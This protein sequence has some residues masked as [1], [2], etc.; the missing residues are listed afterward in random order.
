MLSYNDF[1]TFLNGKLID[2]EDPA[3]LDQ[4]FDLVIAWVDAIG[5]PRSTI[6]H[7]YAYQIFTEPTATTSQYFDIIPNTPSGVPLQGDIVVWS[8][9]YNGTAGHTGVAT[10]NGNTNTFDCF[11]QND[12]LG[13]NCHVKTYNYNSVL[14]WL[15]PKQMPQDQQAIIDELRTERDKNWNLYQADEATLANLNQI[16]NDRNN[17]ITQLNAQNS[18]L[19][20]QLTAAQQQVTTLQPIAAQVPNLQEQIAQYNHDKSLWIPQE[21]AYK[22]EIAK[23]KSDLAAE[24]PQGFWNK[25]KFLFS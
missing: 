22:L 9:T 8:Q 11:E 19:T 25:L 4:C 20:T 16:I 17:D 1:F 14:G 12:P 2:A 15:H 7:L 21:N 13:S 23:L 24:K 3:D 5:I 10:G 6:E 18:T